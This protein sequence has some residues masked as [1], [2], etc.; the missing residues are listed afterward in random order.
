MDSWGENCFNEF[1][2]PRRHVHPKATITNNFSTD[3]RREKLYRFGELHLYCTS[4]ILYCTVTVQVRGAAADPRPRGGADGLHRLARQSRRQRDPRGAQ[5][6]R[7][8]RQGRILWCS[9]NV[10]NASPCI[11]H[12]ISTRCCC[13][14]WRSL[15]SRTRRPSSGS[16]TRCWRAG[17][18]TPR[19]SHT[20]SPPCSGRSGCPSGGVVLRTT[21]AQVAQYSG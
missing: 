4:T 3:T 6:P 5:V 20:A 11:H 21:H 18:S 2:W 10:S 16:A 14:T 15:R 13:V 12:R 9:N 17:R 7:F 8:R 19:P 1:I